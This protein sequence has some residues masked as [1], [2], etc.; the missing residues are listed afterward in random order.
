M[1]TRQS[2]GRQPRRYQELGIFHHSSFFRGGEG[3]AAGEVIVK[4]GRIELVTDQSGHYAPGRTRTRQ[5]LDR[6][7]SQGIVV[8]PRSIRFIAPPRS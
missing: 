1:S 4:D 6:L 3:A 5:F 2:C 7:A 8:D